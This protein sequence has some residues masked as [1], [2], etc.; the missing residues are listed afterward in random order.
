MLNRRLLIAVALLAVVGVLVARHL[1]ADPNAVL[2]LPRGGA[3]WVRPDRPFRFGV[4][5]DDPSSAT[6]DATVVVPPRFAGATL[7]VA[8]LRRVSV[9]VDGRLVL[10][11]NEA[12][13]WKLDRAVPLP[14]ELSPGPHRVRLTVDN[15][16]GPPVVR[17]R[18]DGLDLGTWRTADGRPAVPASAPW[19][20]ALADRYGSSLAGLWRS[21]PA[22]LAAFC[23]A[24]GRSLRATS[25]RVDWGRRARW[26]VLAA[27]VVLGAA[28]LFRVPLSYG[29]DAAFH[30]DYV[31]FVADHGRLPPPDGGV[32]FFQGPLFY[33]VSAVLWRGLAA[34]GATAEQL[35]FLMRLVPLACGAGLAEVCY[36]TARVAFP[37]RGGLHAV[38]VVVGGLMPVNLYMGLAV[39]NEPMAAV[40]GG[41]VGLM[42]VR[43]VMRPGERDDPRRA[44]W[45]GAALGLAVLAKL[46]AGLWVVPLVI[47]VRRPRQAAVVLAVAAAVSGPW[48]VRTWRA[49][50]S[51]VVSHT[52][53]A[54]GSTWWQDPGYRTPGQ[55][56]RFGRGLTRVAYGGTDSV[57]DSLYSTTFAD[58]FLSGTVGDPG[59]P[60]PFHPDLMA[61]GLWAGLVP[62]ALVVVGTVAGA[63]RSLAVARGSVGLFMAAVAWMYLTLPIY[64]CGKASYAMSTL[65]CVGLLAAAGFDRVPG[66][67][68]KPVVIGL[69]ACWAAAAYATY[70]AVGGG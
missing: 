62:L 3:E 6:F 31:R 20:P 29:Y 60:S 33:V 59:R 9:A 17:A 4:R 70:V 42:T 57:W 35:P 28:D 39:S 5:V 47:A 8:G 21:V 68:G 58:G 54:G 36:R 50:G 22:L 46:T 44:A 61:A 30:Y 16:A 43:F 11:A 26:A 49:T 65:P 25:S 64:S 27:W 14:A 63:G 53:L 51:P 56:L 45:A 69:L 23:L 10:A 37:G 40:L 55:L 66:R 32:Q 13:D 18:C 15:P 38:A 2:L 12:A 34:C 1:W 19:R 67:W 7:T 24:F 52:L 48:F 41:V